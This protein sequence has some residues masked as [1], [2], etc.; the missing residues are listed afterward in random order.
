MNPV[1]DFPGRDRWQAAITILAIDQVAAEV[2][3]GFRE[4]GVPVAVLK[5]P[6]LARELYDG[7]ACRTYR[8]ADLLVPRRCEQAAYAALRE[9]GFTPAT[10]TGTIDP[11]VADEHQW[12]RDGLIVELHVSLVGVGIRPEQVWDVLATH[13][14]SGLVGGSDVLRLNRVGL[15][16][17]VALHA[18]QHGPAWS[19][20]LE[21]LDRALARWPVKT[22]REAAVLAGDL[23]ASCAFEV[24]L[25]L[26]PRGGEIADQLGLR[27]APDVATVLRVSSAPE[28][29]FGVE[30]MLRQTGGMAKLAY[31][32][33]SSFPT[34]AF[35][36]W[37]SPLA[38]RGPTGLAAAYVYR[39]IWL[40]A[41]APTALSAY[42]RARRGARE[43]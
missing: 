11:G 13:M 32:A 38:R 28:A 35:M 15:A 33:R 16:M 20:G 24:G 12:L 36:R 40:L 3:H 6:V 7:D 17:H 22:W 41:R 5:G 26:R 8:D 4:R 9:L 27:G 2:C 37:W 30:R 25:R 19:K 29:A 43:R 18:A 23:D 21:D 1:P 34:P 14:A 42:L 10:G 31:L 39:P